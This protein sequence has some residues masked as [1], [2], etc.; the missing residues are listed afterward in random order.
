MNV[1]AFSLLF[2]DNKFSP[3]FSFEPGKKIFLKKFLIFLFYFTFNTLDLRKIPKNIPKIRKVFNTPFMNFFIVI[4]KIN[5]CF[6]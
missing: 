1:A 6:F 5:V 3:K 2:L 4:L